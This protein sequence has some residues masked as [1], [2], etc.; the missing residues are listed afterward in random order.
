MEPVK[1]NKNNL[2]VDDIFS[3]GIG[4]VHTFDFNKNSNVV[5]QKSNP[6]VDESQVKNAYKFLRSDLPE[7]RENL[8][9]RS[10]NGDRMREF[11]ERN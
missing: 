1:Q 7:N 6:Q 10:K 8:N 9:S 2:K 3:G 5:Y 4:T 11:D